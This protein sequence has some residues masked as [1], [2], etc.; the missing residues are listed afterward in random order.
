MKLLLLFI[1]FYSICSFA[2]NKAFYEDRQRGWYWYEK[3][4]KVLEEEKR[5]PTKEPEELETLSPKEIIEKQR[6]QFDN[7]LAS[8]VLNPTQE[9]MIEYF[10]ISQE[11]NSQ[12]H[13]FSDAFKKTI[14]TNPEFD[15]SLKGR[16]TSSQAITA[17]NQQ[18]V[19]ESYDNLY[20]IA[21]NKGIIYFM[22]SDCPYCNKFSPILKQFSEQFG[23]T[24]IP[25]TLDGKGNAVYPYPK[26]SHS[27][28]E[29]LNVSAVPALFLVDPKKN[30][31]A[32]IGY[33]FTDW[34]GLIAKV[35][36]SNEQMEN[37]KKNMAYK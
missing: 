30:D 32:T 11:I 8:A 24:V 17:Y 34:T 3:P 27:M 13:N 10:K 12:A 37:F 9:N 31:V 4:N 14:W 16:P 5:M 26:T 21:K 15:Y 23:F 6:E 33:G 20:N 28:A 22:R 7:A 35:I 25:V 36:Y 18:K 1:F 29:R 2:N 19:K